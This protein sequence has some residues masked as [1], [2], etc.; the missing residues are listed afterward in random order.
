VADSTCVLL[1]RLLPPLLAAKSTEAGRHSTWIVGTL[2]AAL[3][4]LLLSPA[5][6]LNT[7]VMAR[8][9]GYVVRG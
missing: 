7:D 3:W 6:R 4:Y 9:G 1:D 2:S 5:N 8:G